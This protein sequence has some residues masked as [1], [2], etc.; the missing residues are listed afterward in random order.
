LK[1]L[2]AAGV[3]YLIVGGYAVMIHSE[4]RYTK[5]LDIWVEMA[6]DNAEKLV[7]AL[8]SFG[9]PLSGVSPA[10]FLGTDV[11]Y[12]IGVEPVRADFMTHVPGLL[13]NDA[14]QNR[15]DVDFDGVQAGVLSR[16]DLITAKAAS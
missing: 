16:Q 10:D 1:C 14:W 7:A 3:S 12:Q 4:P 8:R 5:D 9:A 13:F 11:V 6:P 15:I 2:N